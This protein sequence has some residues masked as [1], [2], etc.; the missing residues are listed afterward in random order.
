MRIGVRMGKKRKNKNLNRNV[1]KVRQVKKTKR[2]LVFWWLL[3]ILV[4]GAA[5]VL[6]NSR[7]ENIEPGDGVLSTPVNEHNFGNVPVSKGTVSTVVPLVNI[8]EDDLIISFLD[9]S[10][11]CTTAQVINDGEKGP[12]FGMSSHGKSPKNWKTTIKSGEQAN[13]KIFY[14]PLVHSKFRGPA[15]RVITITSNEKTNPQRQ[16]RIK[17]NQVD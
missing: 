17:V 6:Y 5:I 14:D 3:G 13:L 11:G 8:G 1:A 4:I 7:A 15:T 16:V 9:S 12:I 2:H 10:C